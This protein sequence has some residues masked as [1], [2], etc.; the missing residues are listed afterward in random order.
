MDMNM[1]HEQT[2]PLNGQ[3]HLSIPESMKRNEQHHKHQPS[4]APYLE[5]R[6]RLRTPLFRGR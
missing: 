6:R 3:G 4:N 2:N 5:F 1:K